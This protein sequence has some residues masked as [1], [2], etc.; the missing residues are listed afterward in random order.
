[1]QHLPFRGSRWPT[2]QLLGSTYY[3]HIGMCAISLKNGFA[4]AMLRLK[5]VVPKR[6]KIG[7]ASPS[8]HCDLGP[9]I[10]LAHQEAVIGLTAAVS[11]HIYRTKLR[12]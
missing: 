1:M 2:R 7:K 4:T 11:V 9:P 6:S 10:V 3:A 5:I 12:H 8:Y